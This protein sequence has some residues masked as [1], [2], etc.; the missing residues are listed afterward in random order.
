[1]T[2]TMEKVQRAVERD[3]P[4][5]KVRI[6]G[7]L[8]A[9]RRLDASMVAAIEILIDAKIRDLTPPPNPRTLYERL[10]G[11]HF[12]CGRDADFIQQPPHGGKRA[13][14]CQTCKQIVTLP[15]GAR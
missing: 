10:L 2:A 3:W 7:K 15:E 9:L 6:G 4:A 8:D 14:Q 11:A 5:A 13:W 12:G 1:M